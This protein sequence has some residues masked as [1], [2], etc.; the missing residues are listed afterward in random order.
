[1]RRTHSRRTRDKH[2]G[3]AA[4][5]DDRLIHWTPYYSADVVDIDLRHLRRGGNYVN[6]SICSEELRWFQDIDADEDVRRV[7]CLQCISAL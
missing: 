2:E 5:S 7:T 6:S 3:I 4:M 1:V